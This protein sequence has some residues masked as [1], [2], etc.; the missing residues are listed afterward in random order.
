M[1]TAYGYVGTYATPTPP[2]LPTP[3]NHGK[4][5]RRLTGTGVRS[6]FRFVSHLEL[7]PAEREGEGVG[8]W[9]GACLWVGG[10]ALVCAFVCA[11]VSA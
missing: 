6:N 9:E 4:L 1:M 7:Q 10:L 11:F 8:S 5:R 3:R 2:S